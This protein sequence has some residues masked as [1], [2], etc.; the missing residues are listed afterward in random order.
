[1]EEG[2]DVGEGKEEGINEERKVR[3]SDCVNQWQSEALRE[4]GE[5]GSKVRTESQVKRYTLP[6]C[7][8]S[9]IFSLFFFHCRSD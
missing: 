3:V 6:I 9:L 4:R 5:E 1:M 8:F 2:I 7:S